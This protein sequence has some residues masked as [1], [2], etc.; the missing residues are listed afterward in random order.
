MTTGVSS[1]RPY[2]LAVLHSHPIQYFAPLYRRLAQEPDIDLTVYYCSHQGLETY[3]D[4]GFGVPVQWDIPLL[5][6]YRCQFLHNLRRKDRVGG[7][8]SLVNPGLV[9]CLRRNR[10]DAL[11]VNGHMYFSY[12]LGIIVAKVLCIPVFMR[13][14]THLLLRRSRLKGFVRRPLMGLF[15]RHLCDRCL[16]I[17][18]RNRAFYAAHG[19]GPD[20]LFD[21]PYAVDNAF[22]A[23][24]TA[25]FKACVADTRAGLGLPVDKPLILY[26]S[27]LIPRKRPHDL[28]AA[29]HTLRERGIEA[30]LLFVGS[31]ELEPGLREVAGRRG[32]G[33]VYFA[34][35][36]NQSELPR[37]YAVADIFVLPSE[38]EPWGLVINE[39]MCAGVPVVASEEIGAVPDLV[40]DG[41]NGLTF[42]VG[43]VGQLAR[44]LNRL[45]ADPAWRQQLEQNSLAIIAD[46][47]LDRCVEGVR[48]ALGSLVPAESN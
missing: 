42:R 15:Y 16:A 2:R 48:A 45:I 10:P 19:V 27:K 24:E 47:N 35:F 37:Y 43:D 9:A 3:D 28:L 34:G 12:L 17:G 44:C 14:E 21:V 23:R 29:F 41:I 31:G 33:D 11:W 13:C 6:G 4:E 5:E 32:I 25:P 46:W 36:R 26:A 20:R 38:D 8:F 30:A 39:V 18:T 22:F 7:F 40:R 1:K